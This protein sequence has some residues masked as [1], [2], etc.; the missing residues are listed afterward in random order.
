MTDEEPPTKRRRTEITALHHQPLCIPDVLKVVLLQGHWTLIGALARTCSSL[1]R[2]VRENSKEIFIAQIASSLRKFRF[3]RSLSEVNPDQWANVVDDPVRYFREDLLPIMKDYE[4]FKKIMLTTEF[5]SVY[6]ESFE[7]FFYLVAALCRPF[8]PLQLRGRTRKW[9]PKSKIG[10]VPTVCDPKF[11]SNKNMAEKHLVAQLEMSDFRQTLTAQGLFPKRGIL[12]FFHE[13]G[14]SSGPAYVYHCDSDNNT[15]VEIGNSNTDDELSIPKGGKIRDI[16][17]S[18][19]L[20]VDRLTD[21]LAAKGFRKSALTEIEGIAE[22][23]E[24]GRAI[25]T[26]SSGQ[27]PNFDR[28]GGSDCYDTQRNSQLGNNDVLYI[29]TTHPDVAPGIWFSFIFWTKKKDL[30]QWNKVKL[31]GADSV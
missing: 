22:E 14:Y 2:I 29:Q 6:D 30:G 26:F 11:L 15:R 9:T 21:L 5:A 20:D 7:D 18:L 19:F 3:F 28:I 31:M 16:V 17:D 1:H 4:K 12:Y 13:H 25:W 10:G 8:S 23:F 27:F 24:D